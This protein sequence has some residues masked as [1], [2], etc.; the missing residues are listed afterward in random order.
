MGAKCNPLEA[1]EPSVPSIARISTRC[2]T[3]RGIESM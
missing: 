3:H 2:F 1:S